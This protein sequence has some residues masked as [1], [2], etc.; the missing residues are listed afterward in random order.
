[1]KK[2]SA[3]LWLAAAGLVGGEALGQDV[4]APAVEAPAAP[5]IDRAALSK[6]VGA[7]EQEKI[8]LLLS[9]YE[10]FPKREELEAVTPHA[11]Q[12]L[13]A[14]AEDQGALPSL[15][16]RAID[17]LGFFPQGEPAALYFEQ[18]LHRGQGED[19]FLRH[20]MTASLQAFGQQA[21]PWV[22]PYLEHADLQM[23]LSAVHA[24]GRFGGVEGVQILRARQVV[25]R[26][27]FVKKQ[28][29]KFVR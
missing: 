19:V 21:L 23:R 15:R 17:A 8:K 2:W 5:V 13:V 16:L 4:A 9:G 22:Q 26:D 28:L 24:V 6:L 14:I 12:V 27:A 7:A 18:V 1:M 3:A 20:A 29:G 11:Q 10:F 25:E